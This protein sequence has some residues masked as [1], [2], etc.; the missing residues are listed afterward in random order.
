MKGFYEST[1]RNSLISK[2]WPIF[3][4]ETFI[5]GSK[6]KAP[7]DCCGCVV[8]ECLAS[9]PGQGMCSLKYKYYKKELS[10]CD[11]VVIG[12]KADLKGKSSFNLN[13]DAFNKW[14]A[15]VQELL[16]L[17]SNR[18]KDIKSET[19]HFFHD[20]VKWAEQI[21][22]S[23][24]KMIE[25]EG[26]SS[27]KE[28]F[29][30]SSGEKKAIYQSSKM[31]V[32]SINMVSVF[33]NPESASYGR[34]VKQNVYKVF[35]KV[36]AILF[37]SEGKKVNK[38]FRLKGE[39]RKVIFLY[40]SFSI[41]ALSLLHN[42]IKYSKENEIDVEINDVV[43]GVEVSVASV[44]PF[45]SED[46]RSRIFEKAFRGK[47][48]KNLHHDG[49]G[50]GLYVSQHVAE[51]HNFKIK[52]GSKKLGHARDNM[53]MAENVFSFIVPSDGV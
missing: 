29:D 9:Q 10:E 17:L 53:D 44:G 30:K 39:S 43:D 4:N 45:I 5:D 26:K 11:V 38:R 6:H 24:E 51:A 8:R 31:I 42:A 23:S 49:A 36:N 33:F 14:L 22:I 28:N 15:D 1:L 48:A 47:Y 21:K 12:A 2:P 32:E 37:Y 34:S 27:F 20:P 16:Y 13:I 40:E 18:E 46:E 41:I 52:V 35:D 19:L 3:V 50:I 7:K 25:S